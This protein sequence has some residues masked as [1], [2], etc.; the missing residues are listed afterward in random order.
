MLVNFFK[1]WQ[2][3]NNL[4]WLESSSD[5]AKSYIPSLTISLLLLFTRTIFRRPY[6]IPLYQKIHFLM[7]NYSI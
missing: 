2:L 6:Y 3:S 4:Y 7:K 1:T 5:E